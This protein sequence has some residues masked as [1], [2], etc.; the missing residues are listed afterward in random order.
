MKDYI[1]TD[2][3]EREL[4][5][6]KNYNTDT[7]LKER[8]VIINPK[9]CAGEIGNYK[10]VMICPNQ[11]YWG[12]VVYRTKRKKP[13]TEKEAHYKVLKYLRIVNGLGTL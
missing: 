13:I 1:E 11:S 2:L 9:I 4:Y 6:L 3:T 5:L 7:V 10:S 12:I 8:F